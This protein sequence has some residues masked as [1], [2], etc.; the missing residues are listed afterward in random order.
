MAKCFKTNL[1]FLIEMVT[2]KGNTNMFF[3]ISQHFQPPTG[4][5]CRYDKFNLCNHPSLGTDY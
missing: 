5:A 1:P 3:P 4:D 2:A